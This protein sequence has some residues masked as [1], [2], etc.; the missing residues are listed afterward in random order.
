MLVAG[1]VVA[2]VGLLLLLLL[3]LGS[4]TSA[5]IPAFPGAEEVTPP[6]TVGGIPSTISVSWSGAAAGTQVQ[7][8]L[9]KDSSCSSLGGSVAS[10]SGTSGSLSFG[11]S[12]G[13]T[14]AITETGTSGGVSATLAIHG[15][16][17]LGVVGI[18]LIVLGALVAGIGWRRAPKV[19]AVE[20]EP[21]APGSEM[22]YGV[23]TERPSTL[24]PESSAPW[25][26]A[27]SSATPAAE[28]P[29][30][31]PMPVRAPPARP[32]DVPTTQAGGRPPIQCRACN[33]WN[34]PWLVNCRWCHRA[35]TTTGG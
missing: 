23:E 35:L 9:C 4:S 34:E 12:A 17:V 29:A 5:E 16:L 24:T 18:V 10:G 31:E 15:L 8:Y 33:T 14:Y 11:Y 20:P 13:S 28:A 7:V 27:S 2:V 26:A 3:G 1:I 19:R 25:T 30:E 6:L 32:T 21:E 22:I